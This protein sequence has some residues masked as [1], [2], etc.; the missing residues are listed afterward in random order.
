SS[1]FRY[2]GREIDPQAVG[3]E[4]KVRAVLT[5]RVVQRGDNLAISLELVDAQDNSQLWGEQYDRKLSDLL[6]LQKEIAKEISEKLRVRLTGEDQKRVTRSSTD[7]AEAYDFYLKGRYHLNR[8]TDDG[9]MKGRDYFQQAIDKDPNYGLAYAGLADAYNRLSGFNALPPREGYPKA[10][11]A[12]MKA[13]ELDDKLAEAH[14]VLGAVNLF[15]DWDWSGAEKEFKRAVEINQSYSDAHQMYSYY[16]SA[17]GRFDESLYQMRR[18]QELDPLSLE[19]I[20]AIGE[21]FYLRRQYDQALEQYRKALEM[22]PNSGFAHWAIGNVYVQKGRYDEAIA[23]YQKS[24]PLSGDSPDEPASLGYAYGLS[25][26]RREAHQVIEE[27]KERSKRSYISPTLIATIYTGLGE[28]DQAFA[29]LD[30][31]YDGRD[32]ILVLLKVEPM[33]DSLRSDPRF[34]DLLRRVGLPQ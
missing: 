3:Q 15:H 21:I 7:N 22:D 27:L 34:T 30:K 4:L 10:R 17:M 32:S 11:A 14:T 31:A 28:K 2:K 1:V 24:M 33:F 13:L 26:K 23:E 8:L 6:A 20:A 19:K 5:G 16:L 9:F 12:A 18:A 29:W 25:G